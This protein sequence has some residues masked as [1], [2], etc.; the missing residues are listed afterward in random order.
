[1]R[2]FTAV[3][4]MLPAILCFP[5][6][7]EKSEKA[8]SEAVS[9]MMAMGTTVSITAY[10]PSLEEAENAV[11]IAQD[12]IRRLEK[13]WSATNPNSEISAL[14]SG[15][16]SL[17]VSAETAELLRFAKEMSERTSGAFDPTVYP[18]VDAWGF[19]S[20]QYLSHQYRI[21]SDDEIEDMLSRVGSDK[22]LLDGNTVILL[23]GSQVDLGGIAKGATGDAVSEIL[24]KNGIQSAIINLGGNVHL[25]GARTDGNP[26]R[27]GIRNP[28]GRGILGLVEVQDCAVIT[29]GSYERNFQGEDGHLYH[30]IIDPATGRPAENGLV[31]VTV[32]AEEGRLADALSTGLFVLGKEKALDFWREYGNFETVLVTFEEEV[33]VSEGIARAFTA[34][35]EYSSG[36]RVITKDPD[37]TP[38]LA[39]FIA[40]N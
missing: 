15:A 4:L 5:S 12:E 29:S 33:L 28:S 24:K 8:M 31:S 35:H 36:V 14:N 2:L 9:E 7:K 11:S 32:I 17:N 13:I 23:S 21:P 6:C 22:I 27:I 1:M 19:L 34:E 40:P 3:T 20:H 37:F 16:D 26:W 39:D 18:L 30:H 38:L 10:A 25:V